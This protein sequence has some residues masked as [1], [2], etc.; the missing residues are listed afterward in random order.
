[1]GVPVRLTATSLDPLE[2]SV[3]A[4]RHR[5]MIASVDGE[6]IHL[7]ETSIGARW[8]H[9]GWR[10][11]RMRVWNALIR[12]HQP[13]TRLRA[14]ARCGSDA[15]LLR[16]NE[17]EHTPAGFFYRYRVASNCCHDR[18][19]V[20]CATLRSLRIRAA[21]EPLIRGRRLSFITL[22]IAGKNEGLAEKVNRLY[23]GFRD[24]RR[25]PLWR[26]AVKGG[27]AFLEIRWSD[28]AGRWHPHFHIIA[29]ATFIPQGDLSRA[30]FSLTG[31]S[32]IVDIR[33][34]HRPDAVR[35]YV[36]K[37]ASK[38]LNQSF[39]STPDLLDEAVMALKARRLV[40]CFGDWYGTKLSR[41]DADE[42]ADDLI[43]VAGYTRYRPLADVIA[44]ALQGDP[45]SIHAL[46][47]LSA[48]PKLIA[49]RQG[50][51]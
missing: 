41:I 24:L 49:F 1:M 32:Y 48:L 30:W 8:H 2:T 44:D 4:N 22:T 43:D 35:S 12:T 27:A 15:W 37:Y 25:H 40:T 36:A 20:P 31:D 28:T 29:N 26:A 34:E 23:A 42:L 39:A 19:C 47:T 3:I 45:E 50:A 18:L 33:R 16:S 5:P 17:A 13:A 10:V 51:T 7:D 6:A 46:S 21:I 9:G 38:P 14:F 11:N